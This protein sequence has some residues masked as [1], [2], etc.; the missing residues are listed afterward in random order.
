[1]ALVPVCFTYDSSFSTDLIAALKE[2]PPAT[3]RVPTG[4]GPWLANDG[5]P[6]ADFMALGTIVFSYITGGYEGTT[7]NSSAPDGMDW[8]ELSA[9]LTR[10][11]NIYNGD[12]VNGIFLDEVS[13]NPN[14]SYVTA[15]YNRCKSH[16][17]Q[18]MNNCGTHPISTSMKNYCDYIMTD[19]AYTSR[20]PDSSEQTFGLSRVVV[21]GYNRGS[22]STAITYTNNA[23]NNGFGQ[24]YQCIGG[25]TQDVSGNEWRNYAS[26]ITGGTP[27]PPT[28]PGQVTGLETMVA[29]Q[30]DFRVAWN[31]RPDSENVTKYIVHVHNS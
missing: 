14:V 1:M 24:G 27:P 20:S 2:Y 7:Y 18:L 29:H 9:N 31:A 25:Y 16:G 22:W 3:M 19:E 5:V 6:W 11:D 10:V 13:T 12:H 17:M 30:R 28:K 4:A 21:I 8:D 15:I 23:I 26:Q